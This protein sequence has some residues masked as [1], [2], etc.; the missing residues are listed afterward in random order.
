MRVDVVSSRLDCVV[1]A[2]YHINPNAL[3]DSVV[4]FTQ[5]VISWAPGV[6]LFLLYFFRQKE[7]LFLTD[8]YI[9][10]KVKFLQKNNLTSISENHIIDNYFS[11]WHG[12]DQ[13]EEGKV[14][15]VDQLNEGQKIFG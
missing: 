7:S 10:W 2:S 1:Q 6:F 11:M 13:L 14:R 3:N 5:E 8:L 9:V 4:K 15:D 12:V